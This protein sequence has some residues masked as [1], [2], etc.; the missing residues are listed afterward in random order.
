MRLS[1]HAIAAVA[2]LVVGVASA[3]GFERGEA[4]VNFRVVDET[5][6]PVT[7][8]EVRCAA[9]WP[10]TAHLPGKD[11]DAFSGPTDSNGLACVR[12]VAYHDMRCSFTKPGYYDTHMPYVFSG[13]GKPEIV[14]GRWQPWNSTNTIVL[15]QRRQPVPMY[16][17]RV[18]AQ[19]PELGRPLGYDLERADWVAPHGKGVVS[20]LVFRVVGT[21][22]KVAAPRG[23]RVQSDLRMTVTFSNP[24]DGIQTSNEPIFHGDFA[25]S[26]LV[27]THEAPL[28]GYVPQYEYHRVISP[29]RKKRINADMRNDQ[30]AYFRVRTEL[31]DKGQIKKAWYGKIRGDLC[32]QYDMDANVW[33]LFTYYLNPDGTRNVEFDPA[34]N[35]LTGLKSLEQVG[36]P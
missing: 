12:V 36:R 20:D 10:D 29:D 24:S 7:N 3:N 31:D 21:F 1:T 11:Y 9:W 6:T 8:A 5:G 13:R 19:V 30:F 22:E 34:R 18:E 26:A 17:K 28:D 16:A 2:L 25:G 14:E 35:L 27:G 23:Q 32:A 33:A 15:K 4:Q